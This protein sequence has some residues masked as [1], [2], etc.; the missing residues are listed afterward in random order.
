LKFSAIQLVVAG[1][2]SIQ[3]WGAIGAEP[4]IEYEQRM[5]QDQRLTAYGPDLLGDAIDPNSGQ[6]TFEQTDISLPGNS[7][8][9][10]SLRRR[11]TQGPLYGEGVNAEFGNWQYVVPR[12]VAIGRWAGWTGQRCS[13]SLDTSFPPIPR[14][15]SFPVQYLDN[16]QYS[17]GVL[18]EVPGMPSQQMLK[19]LAQAVQF[20]A[21]AN[22]TTAEDWYFTCNVTASDGG[23]GFMAY[24][25]D[26]LR[27]R[28]DRFIKHDFRP[29]GV[30]LSAKSAGTSRSKNMLMATEVTD[31]NGN[32]VRYTYDASGRLTRIYSN[33]GREINLTYQ[34]A[35]KLVYQAKANLGG[36]TRTW[37]YSYRNTW[38]SKP[39]WEGGGSWNTQSLGTVTQPDGRSWIFEL[40]GMFAE[41]TPGECS[42]S[43]ALDLRVTHPYGVV[44]TFVLTEARHRFALH[45]VMEYTLDCPSGEPEPPPNPDP[46][47]VTMLADTMSVFT[48]KLEGP[49]I[50]PAIWTFTY[51][52]D[53]GPPG[54]SGADPTNWT[55]VLQPDGTEITY[56]HRWEYGALGGMLFRKETRRVPGAY[57][58][59]VIEHRALDAQGNPT[60]TPSYIQEAL[61]GVTFGAIASTVGAARIRP[62]IITIMR[63]HELFAGQFDTFTT[64]YDYDST[65]S[66]PTYSFGKPIQV[67]E[68]SSTAPGLSRTTINTYLSYKT[69]PLWLVALPDTVTQNGKLFDDLGYDALGR[70]ETRSRFGTLVATYTYHTADPQKGSVATYKDA[71]NATYL[72]SSWKRGKPQSV[73]RPDGTTLSR[74]VDDNGWVTSE[75]DGRNVTTGFSYNL[76]GWMV[77]VDR[78]A[79]FADTSI[80]YS[81]AGTSLQAVHTRGIQR[82][83]VYYDGMLRAT[84]VVS[85]ST[86]GSVAAVYERSAYNILGQ[87]TFKSLPSASASPNAGTNVSYDALGRVAG[88]QETISPFSTTTIEFLLGGRTRVT[89]QSGAQVTTTIRSF[90]TPDSPEVMQVTDAMAAVTTHTR[91]IFGNVT[92]LSQSG[93]QNGFSASATRRFWY[94]SKLRLCRHRAPEFGDE[95]IEYDDRN[96][97]RFSSRGEPAA[98]GCA[99]PSP[100]LRTTFTYDQRGR[101]TS[102]DFASTTPDI[103]VTYDAEGNKL[104]VSRGGTSWAYIYNELNLLSRETLLIDART[105]Q[106]DYAY[107]ANGQLTSRSRLGGPSVAYAPDAFGRPTKIS[108]GGMDYISNVTYHPNGLESAASFANGHAFSQTLDTHLR[109]SALAVYKS[110]GPTA[111]S[112]VHAYNASN[113]LT[114]IVDNVLAAENRTFTYDARGRLLTAAGPWGSGSFLYDSLDNLRRQTLGGRVIDVAYDSASNR[115]TSATDDGLAR[116]YFYD[117]RGNATSAGA[118]NFTYDF[119][120]QP[121]SI[122]GSVSAAYTYDGNLNR[123]KSVTGGKTVYS[124]YSAV[125]GSL[126]FRDEVTDAKAVD[127]LGIGGMGVRLTNSVL[128]EYT[129]SDHLG[130]PIVATDSGGAIKWRESYYPFGE[131]RLK[132]AAN[133][134]QTGFTGHLADSTSGLTYMRARYYDPIIGRF[135]STDPVGYQDQLNLYSYVSNDPVLGRDATGKFCYTCVRTA[136]YLS[137][138]LKAG[139]FAAAVG[140][141]SS[142]RKIERGPAR[143]RGAHLAAGMMYERGAKKFLQ[144]SDIATYSQAA[145]QFA[146]GD[147][148][149]AAT[150]IAA[151][152]FD[153]GLGV[154]I[155]TI[156]SF[157]ATP[158]VGVTVGTGVEI[159]SGR[160]KLGERVAKPVVEVATAIGNEAVE[161]IESA[162]ESAVDATAGEVLRT[163][164]EGVKAINLVKKFGECGG[165]VECLR[166]GFGL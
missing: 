33:D 38:Q 39:Y 111:I 6:I 104:S 29:I 88:T 92:Q 45:D 103:N 79:P 160:M 94:D 147:W 34:G 53:Q 152:G 52:L 76:M 37:T 42:T 157:F 40:D 166:G 66:S 43:F 93:T 81:G 154:V 32:W 133:A 87:V 67:T 110:G 118:M 90:G 161:T 60:T 7:K 84:D 25:P 156:V 47:Y 106:F 108:T 141:L 41:P 58:L 49:G 51:E 16:W 162:A 132:P 27:Y 143:Q 122:S 59:E 99:T 159:V 117:V 102:T 155:G 11:V 146:G 114:S 73:M 3:T 150:T 127:Y 70:L 63:G 20:P 148:Q 158:A 44:G 125:N 36:A 8:L 30:L 91:D 121:V 142:E 96:R 22:W 86:N 69:A 89:D 68:T 137:A 17:N 115:A 135:L 65:F 13:A 4:W 50:S 140:V 57:P 9:E 82:T 83:T 24:A 35:S 145:V 54:T 95:L 165:R 10:V 153:K 85:D 151:D 80:S 120:N 46:T 107:N 124:I 71:L 126:L 23:Q 109:P 129:H 134:N 100:S 75:T 123:V 64:N 31:A 28:F 119:S 72:L 48:K 12:V 5:N 112:R 101:L 144:G 62:D 97:P 15:S 19:K 61:T 21:A 116:L 56:Y 105:Y 18:L 128:S 113:K 164:N 74:V 77:G 1:I 26:G 163:I 14:A 55:K 131:A 98:D 138:A 78:V 139:Q 149:G 130:S 136:E 2:L